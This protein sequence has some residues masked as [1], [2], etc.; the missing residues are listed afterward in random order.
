[1]FLGHFGVALAAK[2]IAPRTSLATLVAASSFIDLVW[3]VLL[4][5]GVERV[6]I[7]PGG[8]PFT[9]LDFE[10]YPWSHSAVMAAA[11]AVG[12]G[13]VYAL[14][15]GYRRG[16]VV[17][18]ALVASHWL[19]DLVSHLPDL[20]VWPG[21]PKL[22]LGLWRSTPATLGVELALF[23]GGIALYV[24]GSSATRRAGSWGLA[25]WIVMLLFFYV[26]SLVSPPPPSVTAIGVAS[27]LG[28]AFTLAWA[29]WADRGRA[30]ESP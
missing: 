14:R 3:P 2:R 26:S 7:D 27:L 5:A 21:G 16:A 4:L 8:G 12:F 19:I 20:P 15:T 30:A 28:S 9:R 29:A 23:A 24:A 10:S 6:R 22:G 17:V 13:A 11:W 25:G 1:M 18:G